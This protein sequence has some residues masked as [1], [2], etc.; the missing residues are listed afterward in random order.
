MCTVF[1]QVSFDFETAQLNPNSN[2]T[3]API[4]LA[5]LLVFA[6]GVLRIQ[7]AHG[8]VSAADQQ[9]S[10]AQQSNR[11]MFSVSMQPH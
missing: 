9:G 5:V 3:I 10:A 7:D 1:R 2:L 4:V 11:M 6:S 8:I